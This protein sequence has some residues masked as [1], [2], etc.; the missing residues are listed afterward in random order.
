MVWDLAKRQ[1]K[2]DG[3]MTKVRVSGIGK[4]RGTP[5][6]AIIQVQVQ[7]EDKDQLECRRV[8]NAA[9]ES[10]V[11]TLK[12]VVEE[13]DIFATPARITPQHKGFISSK[14]SSY[15]GHNTI[16]ATVRKLELAQELVKQLNN[17][18]EKLIQVCSFQFDVED[19]EEL[20]NIARRAAF[21]NAKSRAETYS[22]E[23]GLSISGIE[24]LEER[25]SNFGN[26]ARYPSG[27]FGIRLR[28][29][30]DF[31]NLDEDHWVPQRG[32]E[33]TLEIGDIELSINVDVC[34]EL[35]NDL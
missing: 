2:K 22:Q 28:D 21:A 15:K 19:K 26:S 32:E 9:C 7:N 27:K 8:N 3:K 23:I 14:V 1:R 24:T 12:E 25:F 29:S 5:D 34:F 10:V 17:I 13:N 6:V 31:V 30:N 16:T 4:S 35:K 20:E 18:N 11:V 33:E